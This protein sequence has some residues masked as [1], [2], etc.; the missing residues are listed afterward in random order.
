MMGKVA[1]SPTAHET[2]LDWLLDKNLNN[3]RSM[4]Q[5]A[6]D[7]LCQ[8]NSQ[9]NTVN[10]T[11]QNN[12]QRAGTGIS[13]MNHVLRSN[14]NHNKQI[15]CEISGKTGCGKTILLLHLAASY[16][17]ATDVGDIGAEPE[18]EAQ[19]RSQQFGNL[20]RSGAPKVVIFDTELGLHIERLAFIVRSCVLRHANMNDSSCQ[21]ED[22]VARLLGRVHIARPHDNLGLVANLESLRHVLDGAE[23]SSFA[24]YS[25]TNVQFKRAAPLM[26]LFD[27]LNAFE[28][29][30]RMLEELNGSR[31]NGL[32]G[33][34]DVLRQ[35]QRLQS[36]HSVVVFATRHQR[37]TTG[38]KIGNTLWGK[39]V[40]HRVCLDRAKP[41]TSE[42]SAGFDFVALSHNPETVIPFSVTLGGI[43]C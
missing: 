14:T 42:A 11:E 13:F 23:C 20:G 19:I 38:N 36:N 33:S 35:L 18:Y 43:V 16:L 7:F 6:Q 27:S 4:L 21:I 3:G 26:I 39:S 2:A 9:E 1:T 31:R 30:D 8:Q 25:D 17:L 41:G 12:Q 40:T 37:K 24:H 29:R 28:F 15:F 22:T 34:M 5:R 32:S 10:T